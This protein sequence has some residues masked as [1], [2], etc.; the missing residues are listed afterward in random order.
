MPTEDTDG[1]GAKRWSENRA[2]TGAAIQSTRLRGGVLFGEGA[3]GGAGAGEAVA[4]GGAEIFCEVECFEGIG[5]E[6]RDV[7]GGG[8][9]VEIAQQRDKAADEGTVGFTAE[10]AVAIAELADEVDEGDAAADAI[11][12]GALG[13]GEG[14]EFFRAV[15]D[16]AEAFLRVVDDGEVVGELSEF[17]SEGHGREVSARRAGVQGCDARACGGEERRDRP[18][19]ALLAMTNEG[20][21][22]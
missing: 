18:V 19:A 13:V 4:A 17:F 3:D 12:V 2:V 10:I 22:R 11:R 15:D 7:G 16:G 14:R 21:S 8:A 5:F 20:G 1:T 6:G 9:A